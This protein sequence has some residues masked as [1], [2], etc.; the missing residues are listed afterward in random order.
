MCKNTPLALS[1]NDFASP[2]RKLFSAE[3]MR[4]GTS[5]TR[6]RGR[7]GD[8]DQDKILQITSVAGGS[9]LSRTKVYYPA[10]AVGLKQIFLGIAYGLR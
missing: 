1:V 8:E 7:A 5:I 6:S 9:I 2:K 4:C 10:H 3:C